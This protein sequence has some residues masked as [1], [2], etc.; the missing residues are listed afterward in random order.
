[1]TSSLPDP[2]RSGKVRDLYDA[3]GNY[4]IVSSDR[5]SAFDCV[6]PTPIPDKGKVLNTL[7]VF[8]F[9]RT[10]HII[11][12]H[13]ILHR[14]ADY[15]QPYNTL[16]DELE[17]RSMLVRRAQVI[18]IECVVRGYLAGS[19]WKEYQ[20]SQSVCG[21]PLPKNLQESDAL[22]YPIFTPTTKADVGHDEPID[23]DGVIRI[24]GLERAMQLRD[25]SLALY[26][27]AADYACERGVI[28]ADTKF[29]FGTIE[30][31]LVLVDEMCTPDSSRFWDLNEYSAG[32]AQ[33]SFDKQFVRD[34]LS[35]LDWDKTPPAPSLP[36]EI[37]ERTADKYKE[38]YYLLTGRRWPDADVRAS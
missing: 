2:T 10:G 28:I 7:S 35:S 29:E 21:I 27:F 32:R 6:L 37:A 33:N 20:K 18:P 31:E 34:Y 36:D 1:M 24:V 15:P 4:I 12:N 13:L 9:A 25:V 3:D 38:A 26:K 16:S 30:D 14:V 17:G 23:F 8:W 22:P 11:D 19:G 5:I